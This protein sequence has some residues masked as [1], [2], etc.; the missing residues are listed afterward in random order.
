M[1]LM[2]S[3]ARMTTPPETP[4]RPKDS[5]LEQKTKARTRIS[6]PEPVTDLVT[7]VKLLSTPERPTACSASPNSTARCVTHS[8]SPAKDSSRFGFGR[9]RRVGEIKGRIDELVAFCTGPRASKSTDRATEIGRQRPAFGRYPKANGSDL[10]LPSSKSIAPA[11]GGLKALNGLGLD[12]E[13][14]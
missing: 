5:W 10:A 4:P 9:S 1:T 2:I 13:I 14:S 7:P 3:S 12:L 11:L 6:G 8:R